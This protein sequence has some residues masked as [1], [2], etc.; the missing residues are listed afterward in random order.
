M[1][2]TK[3]SPISPHFNKK[4]LENFF[5]SPWGC[6]CTP[7]IPWLRLWFSQRNVTMRL[8]DMLS[9]RYWIVCAAQRWNR[10]QWSCWTATRSSV[11]YVSSRRKPSVSWRRH[12]WRSYWRSRTNEI[13][14]SNRSTSVGQRA[15]L[16]LFA[17]A[18]WTDIFLLYNG[19]QTEMLYIKTHS[20]IDRHVMENKAEIEFCTYAEVDH[21]KLKND[22]KGE[23]FFR[24]Y[25]DI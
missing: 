11:N 15:H 25:S 23:N 20:S 13:S 3:F 17:L 7:C 1:H 21:S 9:I 14:C 24:G 4:C 6:T 5:S 10:W 8:H 18:A 12:I 22:E 19:C 16:T 2:L